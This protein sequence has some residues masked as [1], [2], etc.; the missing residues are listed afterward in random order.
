MSLPSDL[1]G[2]SRG[3]LRL[4]TRPVRRAAGG[5]GG[6]V[7]Q[8]YRGYGSREEVFLIG[9]VF[10]QPAAGSGLPGGTLR[11]DL[12]DLGRRL[13]RRGMAGAAVTARFCGTEQ[14][15]VT[16]RDG[17]FRVRLHPAHPPPPDRVWH[18]M[19]LELAG[20]HAG[21]RAE[22]QL[23]VPP[24]TCRFVVVSDIDDTVM[25]TGVVTSKARMMWRLFMEGAESRVAF[26]G[27]AAFLNALHR[28]ASGVEMNP[29]LYVSRAPWSIYEVLDAFFKLHDIPV[30]PVLFLREWGL[31]AQ[32]PLPRRGKGHKLELARNML[33]L[34]RDLPFVLVGDSGQRDPEIYAQIV[35][36]NP[37]R[38]LAVYIRNVSR[39]PARVQAIE[40]LAAEVAA[41]GSGLLLAADSAA[42]AE[43]AASRGLVAPAAPAE[44]AGEK[45][46]ASPDGGAEATPATP[47]REVV[48][49]TAGETVAAVERGQLRE[50]LEA[51]APEDPPPNVVVEPAEKP[52]AG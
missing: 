31:T 14:S 22:G 29:M 11:R 1:A 16:D 4:L 2:A 43:H 50:A 36:E 39:D 40:A 7:L 37:G 26:P 35:R 20:R 8:P 23:F 10:T 15:V 19:E 49:S 30:G 13:S 44:V 51:G 41:A 38:V 46:A 32:S 52:N 3:A 6:V 28:G 17:Y 48:R 5:R 25:E 33:A 12:A 45:A 34:Y 27:V 24:E 21:V 18:A 42:M 47:T 9:R